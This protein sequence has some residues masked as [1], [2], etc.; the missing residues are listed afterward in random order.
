MIDDL[1]KN[2][3]TQISERLTSPLSGSFVISWVLWNYKFLVILLSK[4]TVTT[5]FLLIETIVF[6]NIWVAITNGI[7][8]PLLTALA[9]IFLYPYPSKLVYKFTR[10]RQRDISVIRQQIEDETPLTQAESRDLK[11][12]N[13]QLQND[14][15]KELEKLE[16][17]IKE[18]KL[19]LAEKP[20]TSAQ[21]PQIEYTSDGPPS[22]N[23]EE[24]NI[25]SE[26]TPRGAST[27][28]ELLETSKRTR[29]T[30]EFLLDELVQKK[31]LHRR[32]SGTT[33]KYEL[34]QQ[35]RKALV[36][37]GMDIV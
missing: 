19:E 6:P 22:I 11:R 35:G 13:R 24:L 29:V 9:Y 8:F 3:S 18:L 12:L 14:H 15:T 34:T 10:E 21:A 1:K 25:L 30:T 36:E 7:L 2:F 27:L 33:T 32:G 4:N 26:F 20:S 28:G 16:A 17:L 5:T 23:D 37:R 31:Y